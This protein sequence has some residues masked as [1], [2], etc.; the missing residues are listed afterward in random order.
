MFMH[1]YK[2][3]RS[4]L[5]TITINTLHRRNGVD[6]SFRFLIFYPSKFTL[7]VI[8]SRSCVKNDWGWSNET[9]IIRRITGCLFPEGVFHGE[10]PPRG[11]TFALVIC[12]GRAASAGTSIFRR[13]IR[14]VGLPRQ[15]AVLN[16]DTIVPVINR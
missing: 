10:I 2:I 5:P 12:Q 16:Y 7:I 13:L 1:L 11:S 3:S 8:L 9:C 15:F 14:N 6:F 4:N